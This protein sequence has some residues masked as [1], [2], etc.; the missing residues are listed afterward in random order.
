MNLTFLNKMFKQQ[1]GFSLTEVM[2]GGGILA[3]VGLAG[4]MLFKDQ[5]MAQKKID[6]E[7][8]LNVFHQNLI[9]QMNNPFNCNATLSALGLLNASSVPGNT[10]YTG[11]HACSGACNDFK[12]GA[13]GVTATTPILAKGN[14]IDAVNGV[15]TNS[16]QL[17]SVQD[18]KT[19]PA[20]ASQTGPLVLKIYYE[21][22]QQ[23]FPGRPPVIK[24]IMLNVR[25][26]QAGQLKECINSQESSVNNLQNDICKSMS[27][28]TSAGSVVATW[29][30]ATQSCKTNGT[31]A[32][33]LKQCPA[34][35]VVEGIRSDGSV[36]CKYPTTGVDCTV[37]GQIPKLKM[38]GGKMKVVCEI[39]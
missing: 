20:G 32:A 27:A 25:F 24:D 17:W 38:V 26:S 4:A 11:L 14:F 5:K 19:G 31:N 3:G 21:L 2:I 8:T 29:D 39:P 23:K 22:N 13:A 34:G 30:E 12:A 35:M 6:N 37:P 18:I 15:L 1:A 10:Q 33:M 36:H 9:R 28:V 16:T 7:Q